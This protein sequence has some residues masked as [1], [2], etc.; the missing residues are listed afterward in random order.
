MFAK[1]YAGFETTEHNELVSAVTDS[2]NRFQ[3]ANGMPR[4]CAFIHISREW[5]DSL[6]MTD[7][8]LWI[9]G[10]PIRVDETVKGKVVYVT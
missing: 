10:C 7:H 6:G 9:T 4:G 1:H 8:G 2:V 3:I 5:L